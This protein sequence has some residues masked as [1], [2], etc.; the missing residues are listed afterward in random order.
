MATDYGPGVNVSLATTAAAVGQYKIVKGSS[1]GV[2]HGT[3]TNETLMGVAQESVDSAGGTISVCVQGPSKFV[4]GGT[5]HIGDSLTSGAAG[6]AI[7]TSTGGQR[8]VGFS[9]REA[10]IGDVFDGIVQPGS[11]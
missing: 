3:T 1:T 10:V 11:L 4:A 9:L 5:I 2:L 8:I 6:V 7:A